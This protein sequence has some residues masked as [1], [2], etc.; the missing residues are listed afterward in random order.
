MVGGDT[1]F[2]QIY[3]E[4]TTIIEKHRSPVPVGTSLP[5]GQSGE[6]SANQTARHVLQT[7]VGDQGELARLAIASVLWSLRPDLV[8]YV[9]LSGCLNALYVVVVAAFWQP[10]LK[11][12]VAL[13]L[14][15]DAAKILL[16]TATPWSLTGGVSWQSVPEAHL[17]G[18][19]VGA[20]WVAGPTFYRSCFPLR[21]AA[22][23]CC[24]CAGRRPAGRGWRRG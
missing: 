17:V 14:I 18:Y 9:G 2:R 12:P 4:Y 6:K 15:G 5:H 11:L 3:S 22:A 13:L 21:P 16:E 10:G 1:L 20:A 7:L 19:L 23:G 24:P 8:Y